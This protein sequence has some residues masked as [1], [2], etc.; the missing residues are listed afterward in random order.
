MDILGRFEWKSHQ[1][2]CR[3]ARGLIGRLQ[4]EGARFWDRDSEL[5]MKW[6][7][8]GN[9][10]YEFINTLTRRRDSEEQ[11]LEAVMRDFIPLFEHSTMKM[12]RLT[13]QVVDDPENDER[14]REVMNWFNWVYIS[15]TYAIVSAWLDDKQEKNELTTYVN[16]RN[17]EVKQEGTRTKMIVPRKFRSKTKRL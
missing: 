14:V 3:N 4:D 8:Y 16:L 7:D 12:Y 5:F 10:M 9:D 2:H 11:D 6:Q 1:E 17:G 13:F 15:A